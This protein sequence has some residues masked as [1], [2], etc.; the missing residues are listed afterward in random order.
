MALY[1]VLVFVSWGLEWGGSGRQ[2]NVPKDA[3]GNKFVAANVS[4]S[5]TNTT[6]PDHNSYKCKHRSCAAAIAY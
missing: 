5:A 3:G 1:I 4:A 2:A 6:V